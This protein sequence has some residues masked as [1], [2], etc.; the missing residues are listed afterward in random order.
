MKQVLVRGGGVVVEEVPAPEAA[1]RQILVRVAFSCVSAGTEVAGVKM[2]GLP[3]YRRALK[4][5]HHARRVMEIARDQGFR[6]TFERVR[7]RLAAGLPSGYSAAGTVVGL[8]DDVEGFA[9]GDRV[10]CAGA[11]IANHAEL[12]AVPV[13]LAVRVPDELALDVASTVTLG[14]IALQGVRRAAPTLGETIGVIGLGIIGQLTA[15]LLR[16]DGCRVVGTDVDPSRVSAAVAGGLA[17]G[18]DP[19]RFVDVATKVSDG[20]GLDS[21]IVTAATASDDVISQAFRACRKKGRVVLVG[22]V[23]LDI[24]RADL[25]DKELDFLISTSYGPG[26]YDP[27][28]EI[29]GQDYPIGYVRWT[30][31][32]NLEEYLRLLA[33]GRV[34]L[35]HL[36]AENFEID[37]APRAYEALARTGP[38]PIL[39]TLAYPNRTEAV[40]RTT[41]IRTGPSTPGQIRVAVIGAGSF[42][43]AM[44]IPN[45]LRLRNQFTLRAV[46]SRTGATA[47]AVAARNGASY[48]TTD[49]EEVLGDRD[50]DLVIITTRHD[51]HAALT[52]RALEAGKNVLVEKP[53]ALTSQELDEIEAFFNGRDGPMLLTGFN[54]RFSPAIRL[55]RKALAERKSPL[56]A[57]YRMNA[58]YI[59]RE[60]WLHGPEGGGRN[61]GE[62]C[63]VYDVFDYLTGAEVVR[64]T[65]EGIRPASRH[66]FANDNFVATVTYADGSVCTLTYTALGHRAHPKERLD[67]YF[68][69]AVATLDDYKSIVIEGGR[70][71]AW[72]SRTSEK[73]HVE[74]L[75]AVAECLSAGGEWPISLAEQLR[76]MRIAFAVE[77]MLPLT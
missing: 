6:R 57:N 62:A 44:H 68:D 53:L 18:V 56:I 50:V 65:A 31:N 60:S 37:D 72:K 4:Q 22:D 71:A 8:G 19:A 59:P 45:L 47:K 69:G 58:G 39:V 30:E 67:V 10:A 40:L 36:M 49:F 5:P 42:A 77:E 21:V 74:E 35:A 41:R 55:A 27:T 61:I 38:K 11:G 48:A 29:E 26:R 66:W 12:I 51:T 20:Y 15:Q 75:R 70:R 14:A 3:L 24:K 33:E 73:G 25:Y 34:S 63:H 32:R 9:V 13:N 43:E 76:A 52:L 54:R 1:A 64:A 17:H 2:S 16:A 46:M 23:G 7:G 28:Y